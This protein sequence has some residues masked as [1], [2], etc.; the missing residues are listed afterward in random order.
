M[1]RAVPGRA[2]E[3]KALPL[4]CGREADATYRAER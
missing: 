2:A 3:E 1:H 4:C